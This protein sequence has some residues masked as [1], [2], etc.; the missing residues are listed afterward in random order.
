MT[1]IDL[2]NVTFY[3]NG[4]PAPNN[5]QVYYNYGDGTTQ[6]YLL[7]NHTFTDFSGNPVEY[8]L[9]LIAVPEPGAIASLA[10]GLGM[11][12]GLQRFRRRGGRR[13]TV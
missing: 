5:N 8:D 4:S 7:T 12:L 1:P 13:S 10:S 11:L 6:Q 2:S 3:S 9:V